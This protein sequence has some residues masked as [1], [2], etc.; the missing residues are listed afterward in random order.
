MITDKTLKTE[1]WRQYF[2]ELL[3]VGRNEMTDSNFNTD[4]IDKPDEL[5]NQLHQQVLN[6]KISVDEVK[7]TLQETKT[8][9]APGYD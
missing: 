2:D 9:K 3:T 7:R 5:L 8:G 6:R 4:E 1:R